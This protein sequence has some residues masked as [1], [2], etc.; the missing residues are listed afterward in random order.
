MALHRV[1]PNARRGHPPMIYPMTPISEVVVDHHRPIR[2]TPQGC[3]Y[4]QRTNPSTLAQHGIPAL[5]GRQY[6]VTNGGG[7]A[8]LWLQKS[9]SRMNRIMNSGCQELHNVIEPVCSTAYTQYRIQ[10]KST[11]IIP[12]RLSRPICR[13]ISLFHP[14][15]T[16]S[17]LPPEAQLQEPGTK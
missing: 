17:V 12:R 10:T 7:E 2:D 4:R 6:D 3:C 1:H 15:E 14:L 11:A 8:S 16:L 5:D 9:I 13:C